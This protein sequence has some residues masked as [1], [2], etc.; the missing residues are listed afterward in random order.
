M[1]EEESNMPDQLVDIHESEHFEEKK[2]SRGKKIGCGCGCGCLVVIIL[3]V[4]LIL[5]WFNKMT[6]FVGYERNIAETHHIAANQTTEG[7][8][9]LEK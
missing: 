4:S 9:K 7:D 3:V 6:P 2:G 8:E 1:I 5:I